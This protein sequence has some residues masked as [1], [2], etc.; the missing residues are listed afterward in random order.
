M[1][2]L[3]LIKGMAPTTM[4]ARKYRINHWLATAMLVISLSLVMMG[5]DSKSAGDDDDLTVSPAPSSN[6]LISPQSVTASGSLIDIVSRTGHLSLLNAAITRA[7]LT[8]K[9]KTGTITLFAPTDEAF[10]A[11][12]YSGKAV[13]DT[14]PVADLQRLLQYHLLDTR[15]SLATLPVNVAMSVPTALVTTTASLFKAANG[16]LFVNAARVVQP[17]VGADKAVMYVIDKLLT[18]PTQTT[19]QLVRSMPDLRLFQLAI[20]RVGNTVFNVLLSPTDRGITVFVPTNAAF[21]AAGYIDEDAVRSADPTRLAEILR[22][23]IVNSRAFSPTI[24]SGDLGTTQGTALTVAVTTK[25]IAVTGKGNPTVAGN[26]IQ[27]D[28]I[29]TNGVVHLID[30]VLLPAS[31]NN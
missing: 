7:G 9:L 18:V 3:E 12:G 27:T 17:D 25:G 10:L 26:L 8:D 4:R 24:Q 22:Y 19:V 15:L 11:A 28:L 5:C 14:L 29:T 30:R 31:V 23:H 21:Q 20:E 6:T 16:Q 13:L 2:K 1:C